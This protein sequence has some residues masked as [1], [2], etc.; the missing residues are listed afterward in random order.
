MIDQLSCKTS[1][2]MRKTFLNGRLAVIVDYNIVKFVM[3]Y[4]G[5]RP[6]RLYR[7]RGNLNSDGGHHFE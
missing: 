3:E 7:R 5:V 1:E 2:I 4:P 6:R